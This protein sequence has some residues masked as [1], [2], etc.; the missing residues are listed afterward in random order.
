MNDSTENSGCGGCVSKVIGGI[1]ILAIIG[2]MFNSCMGKDKKEE[3]RVASEVN[4]ATDYDFSTMFTL[5][6]VFLGWDASG[7]EALIF[8]L[9]FANNTNEEIVTYGTFRPVAR[10][11]NAE[12]DQLYEVWEGDESE[13]CSPNMMDD[14]SIWPGEST[15]LYA[16][17]YRGN[18]G[19]ISALLDNE[20]VFELYY[21]IK[22]APDDIL[23]DTYIIPPN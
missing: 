13:P 15:K 7:D 17:F 14:I 3:A 22:G 9:S 8:E 19:S 18:G 5:D 12:F 10:I 21:I 23:I 16:G 20:I 1:I 2:A 6:D 4:K 11:G